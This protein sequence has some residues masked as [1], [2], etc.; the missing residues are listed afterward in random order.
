M[1]KRRKNYREDPR[2][3]PGHQRGARRGETQH[4]CIV[5]RACQAMILQN[6]TRRSLRKADPSVRNRLVLFYRMHLGTELVGNL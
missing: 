5:R 2:S 6:F 4:P 1:N 3:T